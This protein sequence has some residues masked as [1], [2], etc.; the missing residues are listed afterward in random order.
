MLREFAPSVV[1]AV[2]SFRAKPRQSV[3]PRV[4]S[5]APHSNARSTRRRLV[6]REATTVSL[7]SARQKY[8]ATQ[9]SRQGSNSNYNGKDS[10]LSKVAGNTENEMTFTRFILN[11]TRKKVHCKVERVVR[12]NTVSSCRVE[13]CSRVAVVEDR[14]KLALSCRVCTPQAPPWR[15]RER[16]ERNRLCSARQEDP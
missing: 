15:R 8:Q 5:S 9:K 11:F 1:V 6:V 13:F 12:K 3:V 10:N 16:C 4:N 14:S 2:E 7:V